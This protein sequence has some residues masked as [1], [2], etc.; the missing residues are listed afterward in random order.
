MNL[1]MHVA[2]VVDRLIDGKSINEN[3]TV[4]EQN[5]I[6]RQVSDSLCD[7]LE[8]RFNISITGA[9]RNELYILVKTNANLSVPNNIQE[10]SGYVGKSVMDM[11]Y[12]LTHMLEDRYMIDLSDPSFIVPFALHLKNLIYRHKTGKTITNPMAENIMYGHPIVYDM[13]VSVSMQLIDKYGITGSK[14]ETSFLALHIGGEI[15]RQKTNEMKIAT[16]LLCP[17]YMNLETRLYNSLLLNFSND[18][19]IVATVSSLSATEGMKFDLLFSTVDV[20]QSEQYMLAIIPPFASQ[21]NKVAI[22]EII[23]QCKN[24]V[25]NRLLKKRFDTYF[26]EDLFFADEHHF[27][28]S[29]EVI[30]FLA[31]N[32]IRK[33]YAP[34]DYAG[35][36]KSREEAAPTA[37]N[38][39]AIPHSMEMNCYRTCV[40]V[41]IDRNGIHWGSQNVRIVLMMAISPH[42]SEEFS[43]LY[44]AL[45]VLFSDDKSVDLFASCK[46]FTEF[47]HTL[48]A[49][50][51][52]YVMADV[53]RMFRTLVFLLEDI[54]KESRPCNS[55]R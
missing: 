40:S 5:E 22:Q 20:P 44:E 41:L 38:S 8:N 30:D 15:E 21:L 32:L 26:M 7:Q 42:A 55:S 18:I 3:E 39:I 1:V 54:W 17:N 24:N 29:T 23:E 27:N 19:S 4:S 10:L 13:A 51:N 25:K 2:I 49:L 52:C 47:K 53:K 45:V 14:S 6:D 50:V 34:N 43:R 9:E 31:G 35:K 12:A 46:T 11:T 28:S 36:V 16:V 37:F 33:N 48:F